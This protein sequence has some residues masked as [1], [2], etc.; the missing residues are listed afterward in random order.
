MSKHEYSFCPECG[1]KLEGDEFLCP[2]CGFRLVSEPIQQTPVEQTPPAMDEFVPPVIPTVKEVPPVVP[3]AKEIIP[4]E[5]PPVVEPQKTVV[6]PVQQVIPTVQP[7]AQVQTP[8][9]QEMF[10]QQPI[11]PKRKKRIGLKIF[12]VLLILIIVG[13]GV[14]AL[15]LNQGI[16]PRDSVEQIIP[17]EIL[18]PIAPKPAPIVSSV[19]KVEKVFFVVHSATFVSDKKVAMVSNTIEPSNYIGATEDG[20]TN[21]FRKFAR[22]KYSDD[23]FL[24]KN[25]FVRTFNEYDAAVS[26][27][28]K[29]KKDYTKKGYE[30]RLLEV[31]Y[32]N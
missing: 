9:N 5:V 6:P 22:I 12:L 23:Y 32:N 17:A 20:V 3:V 26:E 8:N 15:L 24:F 4:N 30:L 28:E 19:P 16:I 29:I 11:A 21:A 14:S 25:I 10:V 2:S 27:R 7:Q 31:V 13:G 18:D 1:N